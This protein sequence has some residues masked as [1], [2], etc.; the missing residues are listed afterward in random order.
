[1]PT[2]FNTVR[3]ARMY[4]DY[5]V[6]RALAWQPVDSQWASSAELM[7]FGVDDPERRRV[8]CE[9]FARRAAAE[10]EEYSGARAKWHQAF[11]PVFEAT[12]EYPGSKDFLGASML[13]IQYVSS[14]PMCVPPE[15]MSELIFDQYT[16]HY[17]L[18]VELSRE[19]LEMYPR[20]KSRKAV[21]SFDDGFVA[22]LFQTAIR[23]R[24]RDI[25]KQAL[26]LLVE[27]PRREG[28]WDSAAA[29]KVACWLVNLEEEEMVDGFVPESSRLRIEKMDTNMMDRKVAI[30]C[31]KW[32]DDLQGRYD[33]EDV[34]LSW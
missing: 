6:K 5:H 25:R 21:F 17:R 11:L 26:K 2:Q 29:A 8:K 20:T 1:M 30:R 22:S 16:P 19:L 31:S 3:E 28:L 27:H 18:L 15:E 14:I 23:S 9:E 24:D 7:N 32:D 34:V 4:C 10:F 13:M 33:L 12:R